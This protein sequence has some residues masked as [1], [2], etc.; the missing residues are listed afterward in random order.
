MS[1][2]LFAPFATPLVGVPVEAVSLVGRM[3]DQPDAP[4]GGQ[5]ASLQ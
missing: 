5:P 3:D 4:P 1:A 2:G